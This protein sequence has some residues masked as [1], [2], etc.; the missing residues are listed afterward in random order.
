MHNVWVSKFTTIQTIGTAITTPNTNDPL[1]AH[2]A[3][4]VLY[5]GITE[6]CKK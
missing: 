3:P 2:F 6:K 5:L 4:L 1:I